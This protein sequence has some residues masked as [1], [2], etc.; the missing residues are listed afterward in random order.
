MFEDPSNLESNLERQIGFVRAAETKLSFIVAMLGILTPSVAAVSSAMDHSD[1]WNWVVLM[2]NVAVLSVLFSCCFRALFPQYKF[3]HQSLVFFGSISTH[4]FEI[5]RGKFLNLS[6]EEYS[7]HVLFSTWANAKIA[8]WK[9]DQMRIA[10]AALYL[11][12]VLAAV[13]IAMNFE[14]ILHG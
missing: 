13:L 6:R 11:E 5:F 14:K 9:Y 8:K 1:I 7:N 3:E 2:L 10:M 12:F 4:D